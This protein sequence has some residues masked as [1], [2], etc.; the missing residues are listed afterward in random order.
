MTLR[1]F[2]GTP[3]AARPLLQ[4]SHALMQSLFPAEANHYLSLDALR[5]PGIHFFLAQGETDTPV[6][7]AALAQYPG[8][9]EVKSMF[10]TE[11]ARGTGVGA[12]LLG[13]VETRARNL[14]L[15]IL[16]LETGSK[17]PAAHRLYAR[18]GF[19]PCP[20]FGAYTD[21][22]YNLFFEKRLA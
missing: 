15:P 17:L 19:R 2:P 22:P 3:E 1:V 7:C 21:G 5:A 13:A 20:P 18:A 10:V 6:G 9:G 4:A 12:A 14:G 8:Y 16:R 11:A